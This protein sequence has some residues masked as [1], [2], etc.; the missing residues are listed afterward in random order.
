MTSTKLA[1]FQNKAKISQVMNALQNYSVST[2]FYK[3]KT[4]NSEYL[5]ITN[6]NDK[7][8]VFRFSD[9]PENVRRNQLDVSEYPISKIVDLAVKHVSIDMRRP[10]VNFWSRTKL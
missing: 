8:L 4:T 1:N 2:K 5:A 3:S 9:H 7:C 10:K 6:Y